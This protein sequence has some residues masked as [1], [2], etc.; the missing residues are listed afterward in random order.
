LFQQYEAMNED[1]DEGY[2]Y[3]YTAEDEIV[4]IAG[5]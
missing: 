5:A 2:G 1:T 3:E 4:P